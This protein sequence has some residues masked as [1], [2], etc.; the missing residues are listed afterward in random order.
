MFAKLTDTSKA[1]I[2]SVLV[3]F[4]ALA[5][6]LVIN[7]LGITSEFVVAALYASNPILAVLI[8]RLVVTRDSLSKE[9]LTMLGLHRLGLSVW[10]IAIATTQGGRG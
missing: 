3:L 6:G 5:A 8:M 1:A 9:G 10:W 2:F 7:V 4:L